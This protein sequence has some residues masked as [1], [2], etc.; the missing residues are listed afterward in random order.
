V[1]D[2]VGH[3]SF[4]GATSGPFSKVVGL[5]TVLICIPCLEVRQARSD[6]CLGLHNPGPIRQ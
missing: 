4:C 3:C 6:F 2:A 1:T 5:F